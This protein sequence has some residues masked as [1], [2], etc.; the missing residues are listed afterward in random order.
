MAFIV[1]CPNPKCKKFML[2]E[3]RDRDKVVNCLVC[4]SPIKVGSEPVQATTSATAGPTR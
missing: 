3:A 2:V 1:Q 4:K